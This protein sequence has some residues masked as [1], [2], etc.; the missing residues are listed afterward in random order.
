MFKLGIIIVKL[1]AV[2]IIT[3]KVLFLFINLLY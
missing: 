2:I 1:L 3:K